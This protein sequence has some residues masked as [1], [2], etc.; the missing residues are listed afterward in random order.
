MSINTKRLLLRNW[1]ESDF[2]PF[3]AMCADKEVMRYFPSTL[4]RCES[5]ATAH[6]IKSLIDERGWGFWA[7]EI[8]D[9]CEFIGFVGLHT[10]SANLPFA[11]CVEVGWRLN[12][13][14]WGKGYATEAASAAIDYGFSVLQLAEIVAFTAALNQPSINVMRRVG[15]QDAGQDFQHPGVPEHSPLRHHVLYRIASPSA[16]V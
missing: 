4:T 3:C 10:P 7:V 16:T 6:K 14:F 15:M 8:P 2:D 1:R 9:C 5:L 12:K 13:A 11:P